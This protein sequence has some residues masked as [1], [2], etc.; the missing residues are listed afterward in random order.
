MIENIDILEN[1]TNNGGTFS[2]N[3]LTVLKIP[4]ILALLGNIFFAAILFL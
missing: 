3:I 1:L 2:L 4:I